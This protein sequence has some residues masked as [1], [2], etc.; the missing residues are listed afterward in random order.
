M[1]PNVAHALTFAAGLTVGTLSAC[2]AI[3]PAVTV[4]QTIAPAAGEALAQLVR[5]RWGRAAEVDVSTAGC[6]RTTP[7]CGA[8]IVGDDDREYEYAVC[9]AKA[10]GQ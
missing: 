7:E 1:K 6:F 3:P 2:A 5:E 4:L 9:R 10:V 8:E